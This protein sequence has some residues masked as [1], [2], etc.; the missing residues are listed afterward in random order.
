[1]SDAAKLNE[2][3]QNI[4]KATIQHYIATAEPVGSKTLAQEY[5]FSISSATIR[6][7]MGKLERVGLLYQPHTSAGRI[8]SDFGYRTYVD[9]LITPAEINLHRQQHDLGQQLHGIE[10]QSFEVLLRGAAKMLASLSGYIALVSLPQYH[11]HCLRHLQLVQV[12]ESEIM[13]I[14]VTDTRLTQSIIIDTSALMAD[15]EI[16]PQMSQEL[17]ILSNFLNHKL[18]NQD[19]TQLH[20]LDLDELDREFQQYAQ[21]LRGLLNT[22]QTMAQPLNSSPLVIHGVAEVLRQ[23]EFTQLE[24]VQMLLHLLEEQPEQLWRLFDDSSGTDLDSKRV[25]I[26][27]GTEN[28]L[29]PMRTCAIVAADYH[30]GGRAVGIV[31][32]IGPTRML[33][34]N[35][36]ALVESTADYLSQTLNYSYS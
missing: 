28:Q 34:Q 22:I 21:F 31:G 35:A 29:E 30:Q 26:K 17:Q 2:R 6:S 32:M 7:V 33:Y 8:P 20:Q 5:N 1:M 16:N 36:I 25:K 14:V 4:L 18:E 11:Q 3:H 23:P 27:I 19:L 10:N 15:E 13:L 24:Q 9:C 12:S